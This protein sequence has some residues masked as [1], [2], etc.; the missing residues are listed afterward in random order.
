MVNSLHL[1]YHLHHLHLTMVFDR[2]QI[3]DDEANSSSNKLF[4]YNLVNY[5]SGG[6]L[7]NVY[8]REGIVGVEDLLRSTH[9]KSNMY[10]DG[11][12]KEFNTSKASHILQN[13]NE[14]HKPI[15]VS[16]I[17]RSL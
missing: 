16:D 3:H 7:L 11:S 14:E 17:G 4:I 8:H 12:G 15:N 1:L 2:I 13:V 9:F 6:L 5:E 10:C